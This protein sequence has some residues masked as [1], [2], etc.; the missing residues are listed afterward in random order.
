MKKNKIFAL[1]FETPEKARESKR[2]LDELVEL[3]AK[4]MRLKM[5]VKEGYAKNKREAI[6]FV[7]KEEKRNNRKK[8]VSN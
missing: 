8:K 1:T 7:R 6:E 3:E 5:L 2:I 4:E